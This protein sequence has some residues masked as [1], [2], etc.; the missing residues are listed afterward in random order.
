MRLNPCSPIALV[1]KRY[2]FSTWNP[3]STKLLAFHICK[4][5]LLCFFN[6]STD[7]LR[8]ERGY[9]PQRCIF[10]NPHVKGRG[11]Y[12]NTLEQKPTKMINHQEFMCTIPIEVLSGV[13]VGFLRFRILGQSAPSSMTN[14]AQDAKSKNTLLPIE[15]SSCCFVEFPSL[16]PPSKPSFFRFSSPTTRMMTKPETS[17]RQRDQNAK[18]SIRRRYSQSGFYRAV[19][20]DFQPS[21][22]KPNRRRSSQTVVF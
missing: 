20:L 13:F 1:K 9:L 4:P 7:S 16:E 22:H 18:F 12:G 6:N 15:V 10:F 17:A 8:E 3:E 11:I 5:I 19:L 21:D 2:C 14:P